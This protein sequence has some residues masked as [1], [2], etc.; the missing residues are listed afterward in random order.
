MNVINVHDSCGRCKERRDQK[1]QN[2]KPPTQTSKERLKRA[3]G[4]RDRDEHLQSSKQL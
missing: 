3:S 2:V 1:N 4:A